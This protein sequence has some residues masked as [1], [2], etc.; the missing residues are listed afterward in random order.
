MGRTQVSRPSLSPVELFLRSK[1]YSFVQSLNLLRN[2]GTL[3]RK[4]YAHQRKRPQSATR[5]K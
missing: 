5:Q 1:L 3:E 4:E 2:N